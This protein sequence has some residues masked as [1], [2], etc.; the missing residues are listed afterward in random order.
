MDSEEKFDNVFRRCRNA[1]LIPRACSLNHCSSPPHRSQSTI[2]RSWIAPSCQSML[3]SRQSSD[4]LSSSAALVL[5]AL[6]L[7]HGLSWYVLRSCGLRLC[8]LRWCGLRLCGL[9][10][11]AR[12]WNHQLSLS[13][14]ARAL[15]RPFGALSSIRREHRSFL[16]VSRSSCCPS[17]S[18]LVCTRRRIQHRTLS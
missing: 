11:C 6:P 3:C 8:G 2:L 14:L 7:R 13:F 10:L 18:F 16:S 4:T 17:P 12:P 9:R 15:F 1:S 5:C